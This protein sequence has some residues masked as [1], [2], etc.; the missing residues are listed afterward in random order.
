MNA[1]ET[2]TLCD[3]AYQFLADAESFIEGQSDVV[4]GLDGPI[5]NKAMSLMGELTPLLDK[6]EKREIAKER[7]TIQPA[8]QKEKV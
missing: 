7:R 3:E 4:D 2:A 1:Q 8:P 5:P 6:L